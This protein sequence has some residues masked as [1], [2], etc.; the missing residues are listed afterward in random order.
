MK[1]CLGAFHRYKTVRICTR[2]PNRE[3]VLLLVE[4]WLSG[5]VKLQM[6]KVYLFVTKNQ[7]S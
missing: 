1:D 4:I 5:H 3:I 7:L 6:F 2:K